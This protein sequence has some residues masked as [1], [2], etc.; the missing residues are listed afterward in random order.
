MHQYMYRDMCLWMLFKVNYLLFSELYYRM[1]VCMYVCIY[2]VCACAC[3]CV[4][5]I[6]YKIEAHVHVISTS[7]V[8]IAL[9]NPMFP[10]DHMSIRHWFITRI[11]L[12][13]PL[14]VCCNE[15][16]LSFTPSGIST[17][18]V[19]ITIHFPIGHMT[20]ITYIHT[21]IHTHKVP[22]LTVMM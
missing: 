4:C 14:L 2:I 12:L 9:T 10:W 16:S 13:S 7:K 11:W 22:F 15:I 21:C 18:R 20:T 5:D 1:Y 6:G 8:P 3:V 19:T 17:L